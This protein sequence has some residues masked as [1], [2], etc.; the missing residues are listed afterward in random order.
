MELRCGS[1]GSGMASACADPTS[2]RATLRRRRRAQRLPLVIGQ[3]RRKQHEQVEDGER[4]QAVSGAAI[5]LAASAQLDREHNEESLRR[6]RRPRH[7]SGRQ[8]RVP[9]AAAKPGPKERCR[10]RICRVVA[11]LPAT[12]GSMGT[13]ARAYSSAAIERQ[14]P[15]M[16]RRPQ[17]DDEEQNERLEPDLSGRRCPADHR[18]KRAGGAA[19]DD[20]LWRLPLQPHRVHDDVE[21]DRE[22]EQRGRFD[23]ESREQ[24]PRLRRT[25]RTSPNTSASAREILPRGIGRLAV[26][27]I[28]ASMSASYHML[29]TPAAPAPA[30]I[31]RIAM[32]ARSGSR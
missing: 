11:A 10:S 6:W 2:V 27:A 24:E 18:R 8:T 29:S 26:R 13:P 31:A 21:E 25:A 20:V 7:R 12:T 19:D 32:D 30:A 14:R 5:G 17:E 9:T 16:R 1:D 23:I 28:T 22:G 4:E 15:E 3:E